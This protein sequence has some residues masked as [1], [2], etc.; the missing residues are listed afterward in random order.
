MDD[1]QSSTTGENQEE[2]RR[3]KTNQNGF[4]PREEEN[5]VEFYETSTKHPLASRLLAAILVC[6]AIFLPLFG[7][8]TT[9]HQVSFWD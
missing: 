3:K 7:L 5:Y 6:P 1:E 4:P 9:E 8:R 2:G